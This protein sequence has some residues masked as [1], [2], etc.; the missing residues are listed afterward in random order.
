MKL[1]VRGSSTILRELFGELL[2]EGKGIRFQARGCS[3]YP[4]IRDEEFITVVPVELSELKVGDILAFQ[5]KES[6]KIVVHRLIKIEKDDG[7]PSLLISAG[8]N[9]TS[10]DPP[11]CPSEYILGKV[12]RIERDGREINLESRLN[13]LRAYLKACVLLSRFYTTNRMKQ[14]SYPL[15]VF[16]GLWDKILHRI[17]K[18]LR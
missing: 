11:I 14:R 1:I 4:S 2:K 15:M 6:K 8:D 12:V 10:P 5:D 13:C 9:L 7:V 18:C 17:R 3:M 16:R